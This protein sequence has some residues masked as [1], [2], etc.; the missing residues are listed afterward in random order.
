[1]V[2]SLVLDL[3]AASALLEYAFEVDAGCG[4][5]CHAHAVISE[6]IERFDVV[7]GLAGHDRMNA[8]GV[9]AD[10]AAESAAIVRGRIRCEREMVLFSGSA[11]SVEH[12]SGL[13]ARDTAGGIDLKNPRHVLREIEDDGDVA[14][15]SGERRAAAAAKQRR[16][17]LAAQRNRGENIVSIA[18]Q[19]DADGDLAVVGAVGGVEGT[20][21]AIEADILANPAAKFSAQGFCQSSGVH[22][23][24][25]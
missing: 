8:A 4:A 1:M 7:V 16:T 3:G 15:L 2:C 21:A 25:F 19:Y 22:Q 20:G 5:D 24:G 23:R 13:N 11:E 10:H 17:K 18:G 12:D 9:V 14:A 6:D